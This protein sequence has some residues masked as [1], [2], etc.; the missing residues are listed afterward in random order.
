MVS[1]M[2]WSNQISARD[3]F[4]PNCRDIFNST[5]AYAVQLV[6]LRRIA[7]KYV[8]MQLIALVSTTT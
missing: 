3:L 8:R 7:K 6:S 1:L 2:C 5:P 4:L